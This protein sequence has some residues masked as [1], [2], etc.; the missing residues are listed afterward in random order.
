MAY[1]KIAEKVFLG[2]IIF[3]RNVFIKMIFELNIT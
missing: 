1:N 2:Y 3:S